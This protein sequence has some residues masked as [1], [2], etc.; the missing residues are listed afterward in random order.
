MIKFKKMHPDAIIPTR[1]TEGSAGFDIYSLDDKKLE[2]GHCVA[3]STGI[4]ISIPAGWVGLIKPRSG[5]AFKASI[6][7]MAGVIDSDYTGEVKVLL[8]CHDDII[9]ESI[10]KGDRI[11]QLVVVPF[12]GESMEVEELD[13]TERGANG[14][15]STGR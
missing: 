14:F 12:M 5:L 2:H 6:D 3:F 13:D 7:S 1:A 11:A 9:L 8:T 10:E 15:G 4:C